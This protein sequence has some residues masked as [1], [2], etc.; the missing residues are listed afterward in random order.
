MGEIDLDRDGDEYVPGPWTRAEVA[1]VRVLRQQE[2]MMAREFDG[3]VW[4][5]MKARGAELEKS[6]EAVL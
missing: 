4:R 2:K 5:S 1:E 3:R 6:G